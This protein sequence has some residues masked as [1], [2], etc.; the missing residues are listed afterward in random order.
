MALRTMLLTVAA[1]VA[2]T[3]VVAQAGARPQAAI[4]V[5]GTYTL[6][7]KAKARVVCNPISKANP[8]ILRCTESGVVLEYT[9]GLHGRGVNAFKG[10]IDCATGKSYT[11]GTETFTGSIDGVGS[12]TVT[13]GVQF[14]GTFDCKKGAVTSTSATQYVLSGTGALG[15]LYGSVHRGPGTYSGI[16]RPVAVS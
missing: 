11:H 5:S 1:V 15:A 12:G 7:T 14:S 10:V 2:A 4:H 8:A 3:A 16:V 13:W 9:G 6:D